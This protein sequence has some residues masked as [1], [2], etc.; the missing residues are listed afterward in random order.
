MLMGGLNCDYK[1]GESLSSN[2]LHQIEILYGM[3][4]LINSPTRV[5]LTTSTIIDVMCCTE[6]RVVRGE[7]RRPGPLLNSNT[8]IFPKENFEISRLFL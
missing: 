6:Q 3:R 7:S 5:T 4:Q 2:P 1:L 8:G